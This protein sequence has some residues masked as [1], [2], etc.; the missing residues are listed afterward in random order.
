VAAGLLALVLVAVGLRGRPVGE[1]GPTPGPADLIET[2]ELLERLLSDLWVLEA[3]R[4]EL[5]GEIEQ[6]QEDLNTLLDQAGPDPTEAQLL[7][8]QLWEARIR[9]WTES[10]ALHGAQIMEL[11]SRV[12]R[13][14]SARAL[15]LPP[16]DASAFADVAEVACDG[17][18]LGG[19]H[20]STPVVRARPDGS[21]LRVV[22]L[23]PNERVL[24][25]VDGAVVD[26]LPPSTTEDVVLP[27]RPSGDVEVVCT[28]DEPPFGFPRPSHPLWIASGSDASPTTS[29][30]P[31]PTRLEP[32][33]LTASLD[34]PA[35]EWTEVA[36]LPAGEAED[37]VG[38]QPCFHCGDQQVP[39]A[40]AVGRDSSFW[41]ADRYKRR[42]AH[43]EAD[44]SFLGAFEVPA[45]PAD[46]AFVGDRLF[47]L[48]A[49]GGS[50]VAALGPDGFGEPFAVNNEGRALHVEALIGGQ[51][52]LTVL[53]SGAERLLGGYWAYATV[54]PATGQVTPSPG[55]LTHAGTHMDLV[56]QDTRPPTYELRWSSGGPTTA[57]REVGFQLVRNGNEVRT[58]VGDT[59]LR[60]CTAGGVATVVS[61]GDGQGTPAGVWYLELSAFGRPPVFER[62]PTEGFIGTLRKS[63][64]FGGDGR[65]YRMQLLDDGLHIYRR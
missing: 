35:A 32:L 45:G 43:F 2:H 26:E 19:T 48:L 53:V 64:T 33:V 22:N 49:D 36:I 9:G 6:G 4:A 23:F 62:L 12:E 17:D 34:E 11:R 8:I 15:R 46:I 55:L 40:L 58:T 63:L 38:V 30:T 10:A 47:V 27:G 57:V 3:R 16:A 51:G 39:T 21:H 1:D 14:R 13:V 5:R 41:I 24:V 65:I 20:V 44:G 42:V 60:M 54:D 56:W 28:Y 25:V 18:G 61:I 59:Y 37:E 31:E 7:Q 29:P 52:Q 50:K